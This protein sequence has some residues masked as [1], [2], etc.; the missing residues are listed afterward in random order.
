V[1]EAEAAEQGFLSLHG[2]ATYNDFRL[3]I[4]R[5]TVAEP[6]EGRGLW[7]DA[8]GFETGEH[9]PGETVSSLGAAAHNGEAHEASIEYHGDADD[10]QATQEG[11]DEMAPT[12]DSAMSQPSPSVPA[13]APDPVTPPIPAFTPEPPSGVPTFTPEQAGIPTWAPE[14]PAAAPTLAPEPGAAPLGPPPVPSF[15]PRSDDDAVASATADF[16]RLAEPL[17]ATLQAET[18]RYVA[19]RIEAAEKQAA[20][21]MARASREGADI[22]AK[23]TRMHDAVRALL[24]DVT[25]QADAF[26]AHT[27]ELTAQ[28]SDARQGVSGDLKALRELADRGQAPPPAPSEPM[29]AWTTPSRVAPPPVAPVGAPSD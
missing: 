15:V 28:I 12:P 23:A 19:S 11:S 8:Y 4:R 26:M 5:S 1:A 18:D 9:A 6:D 17:F 21:I 20:D 29:T 2:F 13:F 24:D 3:R 22:L 14:P 27:E 16:R 25:R 10:R 7:E